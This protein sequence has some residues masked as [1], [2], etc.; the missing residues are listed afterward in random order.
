VIDGLIQW[1]SII[2]D[3]HLIINKLWLASRMKRIS[4][5][6]FCAN[7]KIKSVVIEKESQ[8]DRIGSKAFEQT[9][10]TFLSIPNS[11]VFLGARCFS[12]CR[13]L[14][15]VTF[16]SGSRLSGIQVEVLTQAGWFRAK[17]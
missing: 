17:D 14:S 5:Q 2:G 15:S 6:S 1:V 13:S 9:G 16:E 11:V 3:S 12:K 4:C 10:I 8:L 7:E